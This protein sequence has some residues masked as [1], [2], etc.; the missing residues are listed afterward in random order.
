MGE[1]SRTPSH[2]NIATLRC[3]CIILGLL[4]GNAAAIDPGTV[5]GR[6]TY[7]GR[8]YALQHVYAWQPPLQVDELW[9][10]VT[11]NPLPAAAAQHDSMPEELAREKRFGGAKLIIR[12]LKPRLEDMKGVIYAPREDGYSVDKFILAPSWQRL[13][14]GDKRVVGK[15]QSQWMNWTLDVE[16]SAPVFGSTGAVRTIIGA[17]ARNS[18]QAGVFVAFEQTLVEKGLDAAGV[19]LT[20]EKLAEMRARIRRAGAVGFDE[21]Q[22]RRRASTPLGE[23]R[24]K[25][26]ERV[27]IDGDY[28]R[29]RAGTGLHN[30]HTALLLRTKDGW[31]IAEW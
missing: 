5:K 26:V 11:D 28:A 2:M 9:I 10:Y 25:Q 20:P 14:V 3:A 7:E 13:I 17:E 19:Y 29:L 4:S 12:P 6:L 8:V 24:R 15:V 21:F 16:F 22:A 30:L 18:P 27:D 1:A 23:A 31:K